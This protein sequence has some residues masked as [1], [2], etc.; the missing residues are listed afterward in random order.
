[1]LPGLPEATQILFKVSILPVSSATEPMAVADNL[2]NAPGFA[3]A[4][5]PYRRYRVYFAVD[6]RPVLFV[7][8]RDG[9][10]EG[11]LDFATVFYQ[12]DGRMVSVESNSIHLKLT[13]EQQVQLLKSAIAFHQE[14]SVPASGDYTLRVGIH[15]ATS[16]RIGTL[17]RSVSSL[18]NLVPVP[19]SPKSPTAK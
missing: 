2:V 4:K 1:M 8:S 17:E 5:G 18:R 16:D 14:I 11:D 13:P 10:Y 9:F 7:A 19:P 6:P 12:P 15:D 3:P